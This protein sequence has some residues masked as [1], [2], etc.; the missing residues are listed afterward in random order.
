MMTKTG[1]LYR[2]HHATQ[3]AKCSFSVQFNFY[4]LSA[5]DN[6]KKTQQQKHKL[7][8]AA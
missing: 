3:D 5:T 4:L 1:I 2:Y 6:D 8:E 7:A